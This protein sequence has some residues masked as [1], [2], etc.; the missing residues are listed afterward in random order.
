M[1]RGVDDAGLH[2][3]ADLRTQHGFTRATRDTDPIAISDAAL[4]GIVRVDFQAILPVPDRVWRAPRLRADVVLTQDASGGEDQR[5]LRVD[6]LG[7]RQRFCAGRA[8][9]GQR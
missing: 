1:E 8:L 9:E 4:F 2:A 5:E 6:L 3:L 7:G